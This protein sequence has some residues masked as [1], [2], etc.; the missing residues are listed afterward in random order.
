MFRT[1]PVKAGQAATSP[2]Y[3]ASQMVSVYRVTLCAVCAGEVFTV[4]PE[5][6]EAIR[7]LNY[8]HAACVDF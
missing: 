2:A 3:A 4:L 6:P 7:P 8:V 1:G 5:D